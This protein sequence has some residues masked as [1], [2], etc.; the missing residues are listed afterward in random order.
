MNVAFIS[1]Q[2]SHRVMA[3]GLSV[4][5]Q[6]TTIM[7]AIIAPILGAMAD[8]FGIGAALAVLGGGA[9]LF[10]FPVRVHNKLRVES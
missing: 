8:S 1:D 10:Y 9:T 3:S 5:T 7:V 6:F 2:I 4:E